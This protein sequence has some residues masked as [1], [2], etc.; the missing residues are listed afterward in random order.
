MPRSIFITGPVTADCKRIRDVLRRRFRNSIIQVGELTD[1]LDNRVRVA[2]DSQAD[3]KW[4]T[5][6][7][8]VGFWGEA[9]RLISSLG[10]IDQVLSDIADKSEELLGDI[11]FVFVGDGAVR[12]LRLILPVSKKFGSEL[13][14]VMT[15][16][17]NERETLSNGFNVLLDSG[18]RRIVEPARLELPAALAALVEQFHVKSLMAIPIRK[19]DEILGVFIS[20][21]IGRKAFDAADVAV[22]SGIA[23]AMAATIAL[24]AWKQKATTDALTGLYNLR[25]FDEILTGQVARAERL[26]RDAVRGERRR[27]QLSLLTLDVDDFKQVN[28]LYGHSAGNQV[29][30]SLAEILRSSIRAEDFVFR[31]SEGADEFAVILP[32]TDLENAVQ[33]GEHIREAVEGAKLGPEGANVTVSIGVAQYK[34]KRATDAEETMTSEEVKSIIKDGVETLR[35]Q[36]DQA[37]YAAKKVKNKVQAYRAGITSA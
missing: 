19:D 11:A 24:D 30:K 18:E 21:R 31:F 7:Q 32:D 26:A 33:V 9:I 5:E 28:D 1:S 8:Q 13:P 10:T 29:L 25:L 23:D 20:V 4:E 15:V 27:S 2:S 35:E 37:L 3:G 6:T 16:L 36:A 14:N 12:P 22:G 17:N 34:A